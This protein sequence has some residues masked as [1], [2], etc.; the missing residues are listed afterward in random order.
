MPR[1]TQNDMAHIH[2]DYITPN[3]IRIRDKLNWNKTPFFHI[4]GCRV[5]TQDT[6]YGWG[7]GTVLSPSLVI[8]PV[9]MMLSELSLSIIAQQFLS[10]IL[11]RVWKIK[12]LRQSLLSLGWVKVHLS[13]L[14]RRVTPSI[15]SIEGGC[16]KRCPKVATWSTSNS[17]F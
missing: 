15:L 2:G 10:L 4:N 5:F 11:V 12:Y 16:M 3:L 8:V 1:S 6:L 7:W 17:S 14:I 9:A 13:T